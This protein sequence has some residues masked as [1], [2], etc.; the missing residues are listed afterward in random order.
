METRGKRR[1]PTADKVQQAKTTGTTATKR[2]KV[3]NTNNTA[4]AK[5]ESS[6]KVSKAK[7]GAADLKPTK[8][9]TEKSKSTTT[10]QPASAAG[11]RD[12]DGT[13]IR[14]WLMKSEPDTFSIDDLINSKDSTSHWDGV[15]NHEAKNL[16]KNSMKV[17][18]QV[19]FYHSNTKTPGIVGLAKIVREAY[20]D[21]TA[22][23]P[24]SDY[25]DDK[26]SKEDPRWFM[27]DVKYDRK[28]KRILTLKELQEYKNV[29]LCDMKL[30]HRGRLSVQPVSVC[31]MSFIMGLEQQGE[32]NE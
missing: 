5:Q 24:K 30:L 7:S 20:P 18:D 25:Y 29:E 10:Q 21:H 19:L 4:S 17:G 13:R 1:A 14:V 26:S 28:L 22:F 2:A 8:V 9:S 31:E 27:V 3:T 11:L 15:R 12:I 23:D 32:P 16:M 6:N